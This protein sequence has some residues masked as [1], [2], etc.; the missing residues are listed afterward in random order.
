MAETLRG[1]RS[2]RART[3]VPASF[4]I[5][6]VTGHFRVMSGGTRT[7]SMIARASARG[8]RPKDPVVS[9][10]VPGSVPRS[11][12]R[13]IRESR[14]RGSGRFGRVGR[15]VR[16]L[17]SSDLPAIRFPADLTAGPKSGT[18]GPG[19]L[20]SVD[21]EASGQIMERCGALVDESANGSRRK[22]IRGPA[23]GPASA[24]SSYRSFSVCLWTPTATLA[25]HSDLWCSSD[26]PRCRC[27]SAW[28]SAERR[29]PRRSD[30]RTVVPFDDRAPIK[31]APVVAR[32]AKSRQPSAWPRSLR[33]QPFR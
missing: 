12:P 30:S 31:R 14:L 7:R 17:R 5:D 21:N 13:E 20:P 28:T 11:L 19:S 32:S 9:L 3:V 29:R 2:L 6:W 16:V 23:P 10:G 15:A 1:G 25:T 27:S 4:P 33:V 22:E 26:W 18:R 8:I 24:G